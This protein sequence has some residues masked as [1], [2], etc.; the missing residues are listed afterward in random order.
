MTQILTISLF[1]DFLNAEK[2]AEK[3]NLRN[4]SASA[5]SDG[6]DKMVSSKQNAEEDRCTQITR[7]RHRAASTHVDKPTK[8][9]ESSKPKSKRNAN[10]STS[11]RPTKLLLQVL[12]EEINCA[13]FGNKLDANEINLEWAEMKRTWRTT[14]GCARPKNRS[15]KY[16]I[17]L[18]RKLVRN[19]DVVDRMNRI[20]NILTHEMIH[21]LCM[22][23]QIDD[24]HGPCFQKLMNEINQN[25]NLNITI[26]NPYI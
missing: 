5:Y 19:I 13:I 9:T 16:T 4:R 18:N 3:R 26:K 10:V 2:P 21:I 23:R 17:A 24:D 11:V 25:F 15:N 7:L 1:I 14:A 12:F 8:S 20:K 6:M 22:D